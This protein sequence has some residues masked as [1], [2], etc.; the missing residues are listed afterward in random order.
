MCQIADWIMMGFLT[1]A[2]WID[3]RKKEV[4]VLLLIKMGLFSILFRMLLVESTMWGTISGI[5]IGIFFCLMSKLTRES[6]GYG[7][8]IM[9]FILGIY[10]GG[11]KSLQVV[12]IASLGASLFSLIFCI[13]S[14]WKRKT[15]IPFIPF[16]AAAYLGVVLI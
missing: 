14:G 5:A 4:P 7:D 15:T 3:F 6:I 8:S 12:L 9:I 16:L 2:G 11:I 13:K 1:V 10:L